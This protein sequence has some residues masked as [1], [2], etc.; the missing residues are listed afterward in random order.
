MK[1]FQ[2]YV[3][4]V[5]KWTYVLCYL[6]LHKEQ[7]RHL[8]SWFLK[9]LPFQVCCVQGL[10]TPENAQLL[11]S[12]CLSQVTE[13]KWEPAKSHLHSNGL[14]GAQCS[15][16]NGQR[17]GES[18]DGYLGDWS[19]TFIPHSSQHHCYQHSFSQVSWIS[20]SPPA[21]STYNPVKYHKHPLSQ[22]IIQRFI[23]SKLKSWFIWPRRWMLQCT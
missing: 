18:C 22:S 14:H 8:H 5:C 15:W 10:C 4:S 1:E 3:S 9:P 7:L 17:R 16:A 19:E 20:L 23:K 21:A 6:L 2:Q 13:H 11:L 12:F